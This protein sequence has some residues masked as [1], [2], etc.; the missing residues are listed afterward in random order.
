M[1]EINKIFSNKKNLIRVT[2][3][4]TGYPILRELKEMIKKKRIGKIKQFFFIC[5][6][7]HLPQLLAKK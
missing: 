6:K 4:Y 1:K 5:L 7:M 3:N 2:Y